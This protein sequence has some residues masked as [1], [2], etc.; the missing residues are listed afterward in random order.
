M[1]TPRLGLTEL[2]DSQASA[3]A[4]A[5][6]LALGLEAFILAKVLDRDLNTP[7][8]S[9]TRGDTYIVGPS[10]TGAWTGKAGYL[11]TYSN[12]WIFA[13]PVGGLVIYVVDEKTWFAYSSVESAWHQF[14]AIWSTSETF[15]GEYREGSKV[16]EKSFSLSPL[17]TAAQGFLP[18][19]H[20]ISGIDFGKMITIE[21][22]VNN[23][24][25]GFSA[26]LNFP[27]A[28]PIPVN[29]NVIVDATNFYFGTNFD[30]SSGWTA[31]I[32]LRYCKT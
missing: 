14:Q 30:L 31:K 6:D 7:P 18:Y 20:G 25:I 15:T 9:P 17:P 1:A 3:W 13:A 5:N 16:Y 19:A 22:S 29:A 26:P 2:V 23:A 27:A 21:G 28:G 8:G 32:R 4:T 11:T 12:G 24:G 10:P